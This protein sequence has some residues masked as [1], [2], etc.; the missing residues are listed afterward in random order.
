[1]R[2]RM[3]FP[4]MFFNRSDF[5]QVLYDN[6][7]DKSK[8]RT[9]KRIVSVEQSNEEAKVILSDGTEEVGDIIIGCDGVYSAVRKAVKDQTAIPVTAS[10]DSSRE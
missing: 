5:L 7:A 10:K 9:S 4:F 2:Y 1:M 8:I 3:G 6:L